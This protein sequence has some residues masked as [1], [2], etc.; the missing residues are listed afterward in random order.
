MRVF[1]FACLVLPCLAL[2][3]GCTGFTDQTRVDH[4]TPGA[5]GHFAYSVA[6]NTVM[7]AND[8]GA[9][10]RIRRDW[11]AESLHAHKLCDKGYVVDT[12]RLVVDADG[13]YGNGGEVVY[14]GH[15]L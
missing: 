14:D 7:T 11:L 4:L 3:A 10:E 12:R 2:L 9:A 8:D 6:T 5:H 1:V 13:P 15:C